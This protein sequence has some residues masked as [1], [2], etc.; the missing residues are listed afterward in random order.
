MDDLKRIHE[1]VNN[2]LQIEIKTNT[3]QRDYS[4]GRFLFFAIA[5]KTTNASLGRIGMYMDKDH[6]SVLHGVKMFYKVLIIKRVYKGLFY[7]YIDENWVDPL[8]E[9]DLINMNLK[10][11]IFTLH[12]DNARLRYLLDQK[13]DFINGFYNLSIEDQK[14][15]KIR[16]QAIINMA[17]SNQVRKEIFETINCQA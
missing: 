9:M 7:R 3:R 4:D 12:E 16:V 15:V 1:Y 6:A 8:I 14:N 2:A 5:R 13:L 10:D 17:P 11:R